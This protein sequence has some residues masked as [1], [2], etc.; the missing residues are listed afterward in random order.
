MGDMTT[1]HCATCHR[2][3]AQGE[4][5]WASDWKTLDVSGDTAVWRNETRYTCDDCEEAE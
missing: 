5:A 2:P 4:Q 1:I 3:F